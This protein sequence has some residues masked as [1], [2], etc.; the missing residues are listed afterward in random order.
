MIKTLVVAAGLSVA[1]AAQADSIDLRKL[2]PCKSA[3]ARF[4]DR[5][6]GMSTD[7]LLKCGAMLATRHQEVGARCVDVLK[8]FGQLSS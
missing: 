2:L 5:S 3:A 6:Q 7:A 4:C 8:R 1:G